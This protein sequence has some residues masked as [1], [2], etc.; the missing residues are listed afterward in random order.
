M[1]Y[2]NGRLAIVGDKVIGKGY[3]YGNISGTLLSI[4]P[5]AESCNCMVGMLKV[6]PIDN[7]SGPLIAIHGDLNQGL[8]GNKN[9]VAY[10]QEYSQCDWLLHVDDAL[11]N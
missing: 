11:K 7:Y 3:N 6:S 2:R 8:N 5:E 4:T 10:V 1:H 9:V